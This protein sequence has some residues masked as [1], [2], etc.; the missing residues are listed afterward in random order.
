MAVLQGKGQL[1]ELMNLYEE[2][3]KLTKVC[4]KLITE[5][6][7]KIKILVDDGAGG[8]VKEDFTASEE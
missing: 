3:V 4:N 1:D 6:E 8:K 2:A 7:K 5:A